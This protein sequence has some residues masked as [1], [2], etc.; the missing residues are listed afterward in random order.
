LLQKEESMAHSDA[1]VSL[2]PAQN[3]SSVPLLHW[4]QMI[5]V[6]I[7][8][9]WLW[10]NV[11]LPS[12]GRHSGDKSVCVSSCCSSAES[13]GDQTVSQL[14]W[15][16]SSGCDR[17]EKAK[18]PGSNTFLCLSHNEAASLGSDNTHRIV[19]QQPLVRP[20]IKSVP[21]P[22]QGSSH[23]RPVKIF[24]CKAH[25]NF[26]RNKQFLCFHFSGQLSSL[27]LSVFEEP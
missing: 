25:K 9:G 20:C 7:S 18:Y 10:K 12:M 2:S 19:K 3:C 17:E 26:F 11:C 16:G 15:E 4:E 23:H 13:E 8:S 27:I 21:W 24:D 22:Q 5:T 1:G 6:C 14:P